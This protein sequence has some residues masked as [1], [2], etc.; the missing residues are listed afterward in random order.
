MRRIIRL[1]DWLNTGIDQ[2]RGMNS[3]GKE[4]CYLFG[5]YKIRNQS[6]GFQMLP[7]INFVLRKFSIGRISECGSHA[8]DL[9]SIG[10]KF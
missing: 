2:I 6:G 7:R 9:R 10:T 1:L 4:R 8:C 5:K 3:G